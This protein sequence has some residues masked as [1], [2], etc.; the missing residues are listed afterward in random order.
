METDVAYLRLQYRRL[1][2][3]S[4]EVDGVE[5]AVDRLISELKNREKKRG[6][7]RIR[8]PGSDQVLDYGWKRSGDDPL[9]ILKLSMIEQSDDKIYLARRLLALADERAAESH[10][11][12]YDEMRKAYSW[13]IKDLNRMHS[14][15]EHIRQEI[16]DQASWKQLGNRSGILTNYKHEGGGWHTAKIEAHLDVPAFELVALLRE[17]DL[18][19]TWMPNILGFGLSTASARGVPS[20]TKVELD[21]DV[22][23]PWPL[24]NRDVSL[25]VEAIDCLAETEKQLVIIIGDAANP[26]KCR[27]KVVRASMNGS[28]CVITPHYEGKLNR[29]LVQFLLRIDLKI[30]V[31]PEPLL[32]VIFRNAAFLLLCKM[33]EAAKLVRTRT[34]TRRHRHPRSPFYNWLRY[35]IIANWPEQEGTLPEVDPSL[36]NK[37]LGALDQLLLTSLVGGE[38]AVAGFALLVGQAL[39]V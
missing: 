39:V 27:D 6:R 12:K 16:A 18:W 21:A 35:H 30:S 8:E 26:S 3:V 37:P 36:E 9:H 32:D 31:I 34:Y 20:R 5:P 33:R 13:H 7:R 25:T 11:P 2:T 10:D 1:V 38:V 24:W 14:Q 29:T 28:G 19:D 22:N 23:M 4:H 15:S 17:A